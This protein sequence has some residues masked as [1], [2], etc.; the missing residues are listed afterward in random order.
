LLEVSGIKA[1]F[2]IGKIAK[3]QVAIS[4]RSSNG[5]NVQIIM[6]NMGGGGHYSMAAAQFE[7][8]SI[9]EVKELLEDTIS[10]YLEDRGE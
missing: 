8:K 9:E 7:N 2:T 4:A 6:E 3:N 5:I 1:S 10:A